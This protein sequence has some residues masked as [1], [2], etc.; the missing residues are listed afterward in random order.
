MY[1]DTPPTIVP[2]RVFSEVPDR[3]RK[4]QVGEVAGG[5]W[6]GDAA[7]DCLI[8]GPC[9]D[10]EG[11]LFLV[12]IPYGRIFRVTPGGDW[13]VVAEYDGEPNGLRLMADGRI[14]VA[15]YKQGILSLEPGSGKITPIVSRYRSERLKGPNDL[16][17]AGNGDIYFTD[18]GQTGLHDPTGRV[19][20]LRPS[21]QMDCILSNGPSPNGLVLTPDEKFLFVAMTRDNSVWRL[22]VLP[23][24]TTMKV[25]RFSQY[26]G[27]IGPDGM[28]VDSESNVFVA[29]A[30]LGSIFVH[31]KYGE[32]IARIVSC[33]GRMITN[34]AFGGP[35]R[36]TIFI[37]E[38]ETGSVLAADW[39][40][41]G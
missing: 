36:K 22:P 30:S 38:S 11:N 35:D 26:F 7:I 16:I 33:R 12:D 27:I 13:S 17:V 25:G 4:R 14:A 40:I 3:L 8:E 34:L 23:D 10:A 19:F 32:L 2:T 31:N 6:Q 18:Q 39:P 21:G 1:L 29:H 41:P 5:R 15:D 9:F 28:A 24:G 20:R 37:T